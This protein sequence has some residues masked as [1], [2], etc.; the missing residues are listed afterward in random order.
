M[1]QFAFNDLNEYVQLMVLQCMPIK[2]RVKFERINTD[3]AAKLD[4]LWLS[5]KQLKIGHNWYVNPE[6]HCHRVDTINVHDNFERMPAEAM[7]KLISGC[8]NLEALEMNSNEIKEVD[9][10]SKLA[11]V[12]NDHC[13][14]L[15]HLSICPSANLVFFDL[16]T[17]HE[18]LT[19]LFPWTTDRLKRIH[20]KKRPASELMMKLIG[21]NN[22]YMDSET[23]DLVNKKT[24]ERLISSDWQEKFNKLV[25]LKS[26]IITVKSEVMSHFHQLE[27]ISLYH[28]TDTDLRR[29]F[30]DNRKLVS[31]KLSSVDN[32]VMSTIFEIGANLRELDICLSENTFVKEH[33]FWQKMVKLTK[34]RS[35][36]VKVVKDCGT[37]TELNVD[38]LCSV[39]TTC[40]KLQLV[41]FDCYSNA[42]DITTDDEKE[43]IEKVV[44]LK[45]FEQLFVVDFDFFEGNYIITVDVG[46]GERYF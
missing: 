5:Q 35:L 7:L 9:F 8:K 39:L 32:K 10:A 40:T 28:S 29:I 41:K 34:L 42:T 45:S 20:G 36:A 33:Q 43:G 46:D 15:E 27:H 14:L 17:P 19:C 21:Y 4:R 12:L 13:K 37:D 11:I 31:L 2:A 1:V 38:G 16:F 6:P 24:V 30:K 3:W 22:Y 23:W 18:K 26:L 44:A 25:N